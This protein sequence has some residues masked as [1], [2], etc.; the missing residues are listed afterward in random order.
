[1]GK[2]GFSVSTTGCGG[3]DTA[4][5]GTGKQVRCIGSSWQKHDDGHPHE[6]HASSQDFKVVGNSSID[7]PSPEHGHDNKDPPIGRVDPAKGGGLQGGNETV[8]HEN[9][10]PNE[11]GR[12]RPIRSH[13]LPHEVSPSNLRQTGQDEEAYRTQ[14]RRLLQRHEVTMCESHRR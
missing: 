6:D 9:H 7:E 1:M 8:R 14:N 4:V 13:V 12:H 3:P 10:S 5:K 2:P 11:D